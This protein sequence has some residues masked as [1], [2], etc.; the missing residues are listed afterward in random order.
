MKRPE[1]EE[2]IGKYL[3]ARGAEVNLMTPE[4]HDSMMAVVLGLAH[5]IAIVS[6]DTLLSLNNLRQR[7]ASSGV[8][9]RV[10]LTLVESV[11]SEDP[12]LYASTQMTLPD[13]GKVEGLFQEKGRLWA[14]LVTAGD[15]RQFVERMKALKG[16]LEEVSPDFG[17]AYENMYKALGK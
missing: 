1:F 6:A 2:L 3:E 10:L 17:K 9:Y 15:R 5:F 8:T 7:E 11:L 16:K 14:D 13:M 12:E 4:E